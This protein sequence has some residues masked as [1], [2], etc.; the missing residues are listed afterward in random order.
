V[1]ASATDLPT[2]EALERLDS[3]RAAVSLLRNQGANG[4]PLHQ[5]W[6]LYRGNAIL[7]A[8][9][10]AYFANFDR[11]MFG[12]TRSAMADSLTA[13]PETPRVTDDYG[14][15]YDLLKAYLI[16]TSHPGNSTVE[17]LPPVLMR[18]WLAGR[19]I[20]SA[21]T[22]L[23]ERQMAFFADELRVDNPFPAQPDAP[24][25][26]RSRVFLTKFTG[27]ERIYNFMINEAG[28][29]NPSV[30]FNRSV[31]GSAAVL[32][33]GYEVPGA[34]TKSGWAFM[35][36]ALGNVDQFFAGE[37]W[38]MGDQGVVSSVDRARIVQELRTRYV[39][40]YLRHWRTFLR[41]ASVPR[42]SGM[43]D[44]GRKLT[45][46][47]GSQSPI[48]ALLATVARNTDVDSVAIKPVFHAVHQVTP[49][50]GANDP[51]IGEKNQPYVGALLALTTA[52]EQAANAPA[53]NDAALP[54][55]AT[56]A[57]AARSTTRQIAQGFRPDGE[58][59]V[60]SLVEGLMQ[61]PIS[62]A[63]AL[64]RTVG[65]GELNAR[66]ADFCRPFR[67]L[68]EKYPFSPGAPVEATW[69][70]VAE[71]FGPTGSLRTFYERTLSRALVQQGPTYVPREGSQIQLS[72]QFIAF[73]NKAMAVSDALY[74]ENAT[75]PRMTLNLRPLMTSNIEWVTIAIDG[76]TQRWTRN[77]TQIRSLTWNGPISTSATIAVRAGGR[78]GVLQTFQGPW[79]FFKLIHSID[80]WGSTGGV[81]RPAWDVRLGGRQ[82]VN[83]N[84]PVQ[85]VVEM[86]LGATAPIM[87]DGYF[88]GLGCVTSVAR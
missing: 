4:A 37:P 70:E 7:P 63:E 2:A 74:K 28:K 62:H 56:S 6:G 85:L 69:P 34:F 30:N 57:L 29:T 8:A 54:G 41:S 14:A 65:T 11:L 32:V 23:A 47:S 45:A 44:A 60:H 40:D 9:R 3:L 61:M 51:L 88:S 43:S 49:P 20:D 21:R 15:T 52:V 87:W 5:R 16:T 33:D 19:E 26:Q 46:L 22:Q 18:S 10:A 77:E 71:I 36:T 35:Q 76:V 67:L 79:S 39:A 24:L 13:L 75:S 42:F 31:P 73:F 27:S 58:G 53:G 84:V 12:T 38:V 59:Q 78:E 82:V 86:H 83:D 48:L 80:S 64:T 17:F 66:G 25:V 81:Y 55:V 50:A 72:P 68:M 1:P